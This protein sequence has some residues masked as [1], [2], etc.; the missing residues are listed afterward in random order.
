VETH[1]DYITAETLTTH[2]EFST[3]PIEA[4]VVEDAFEGETVKV[5]LVKA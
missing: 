4:S 1:R 5:G 3:P 2:L